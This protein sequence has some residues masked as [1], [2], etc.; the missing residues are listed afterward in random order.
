MVA[1]QDLAPEALR[2][3][4]ACAREMTLIDLLIS[5]SGDTSPEDVVSEMQKRQSNLLRSVVRILT[6]NN[7]DSYSVDIEAGSKEF[8]V[9]FSKDDWTATEKNL[10]EISATFSNA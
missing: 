6:R 2:L 9:V 1:Q 7:L 8:S 3:L 4:S 10:Q 5:K